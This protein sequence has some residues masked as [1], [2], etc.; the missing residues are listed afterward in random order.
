VTYALATFTPNIPVE[1]RNKYKKFQSRNVFSKGER[2]IGN[3]AQSSG[4]GNGSKDE[5]DRYKC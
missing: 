4:Q 5:R 3:H 1:I 2:Q